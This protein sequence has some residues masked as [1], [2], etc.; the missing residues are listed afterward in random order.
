MAGL[1]EPAIPHAGRK[2]V[3]DVAAA[4]GPAESGL[5]K[6]PSKSVCS[7]YLAKCLRLRGHP[8]TPPERRPEFGEV[9]G[10]APD[11]AVSAPN[12]DELY[13]SWTASRPELRQRGL[14]LN[15]LP[16]PAQGRTVLPL[17]PD[18]STL[19][20]RQPSSSTRKAENI[21]LAATRRNAYKHLR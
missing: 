1:D 16:N 2:R 12:W 15:G 19:G 10:R 8:G 17:L 21:L 6:E 14:I 4:L 20:D 7:N 9:P 13:R 5:R 18:G 11:Y 3:A